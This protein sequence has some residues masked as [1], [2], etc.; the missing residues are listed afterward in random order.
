M[1]SVTWDAR[2]YDDLDRLDVIMAERIVKKVTTYLAR[3]PLSLG[4]PL[5]ANLGGLYSYR[6]GDYRIIYRMD[7]SGKHLMV[8]HVGHR[9]DV[10]DL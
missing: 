4:K 3:D 6:F 7:L 1:W 10:Y 9:K 2:A 5:S 8:Y